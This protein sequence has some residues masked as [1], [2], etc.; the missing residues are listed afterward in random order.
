MMSLRH[1]TTYVAVGLVV[2]GCAGGYTKVRVT[3]VSRDSVAQALW[4]A[5]GKE[6][7]TDEFGRSHDEVFWPSVD[8]I[9]KRKAVVKYEEFRFTQIFSYSV[10]LRDTI[11]IAEKEPNGTVVSLRCK[12]RD[13]L[14]WG[15]HRNKRKE[16]G[17]LLKMTQKLQDKEGAIVEWIG[18]WK[19]ANEAV[20]VSRDN[21]KWIA[22]QGAPLSVAADFF[23]WRYPDY[24]KRESS[25]ADKVVFERRM[26]R[27]PAERGNWFP[28]IWKVKGEEKGWE[29][30]EK[31][32][33]KRV[34][35]EGSLN[36][37]GAVIVVGVAAEGIKYERK[38]T[39]VLVL[40]T[41]IEES[42][43]DVGNELHNEV[44][45]GI[46]DRILFESNNARFLDPSPWVEEIALPELEQ[47]FSKCG[48]QTIEQQSKKNQ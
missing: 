14:E 37:E 27:D 7:R 15:M 25:G 42:Y 11:K 41:G 6:T 1:L 16:R 21:A 23:K 8:S 46:S 24:V 18:D 22:Y 19:P 31:T 30:N 43:V 20:V 48:I 10:P 26:D 28:D 36:D 3:G 35:L 44:I 33:I 45:N 29:S 5:G 13:F 2:S 4:E 34:P 38:A 39:T 32:L 47:E 17:I 40:L 9:N 12:E